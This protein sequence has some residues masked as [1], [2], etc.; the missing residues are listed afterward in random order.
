MSQTC[1]IIGRSDEWVRKA[2]S[3]NEFIKPVRIGNRVCFM[4]D[5]LDSFIRSHQ[6]ATV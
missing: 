4:A 5:E 1:A 6:Q 2:V 3:R